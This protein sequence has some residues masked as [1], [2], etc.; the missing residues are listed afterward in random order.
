MESHFDAD[1]GGVRVH[2]DDA[3][4]A[5]AQDVGARAYTLGAHMV[6][7]PGEYAPATAEGR[8]LLAHELTHVIQQYG[9]P[10]GAS[11]RPIRRSAHTIMRA[12][13]AKESVCIRPVRVADDDGKNPTTVPSLD[14]SQRVWGK[15][16]VDLS[17][18]P[19]AIVKKR[20]YKVLD[21]SPNDVPTVE[22][23]ALFTDAGAG[24]GC[25]S[26]FVPE[27]FQQG[28][29]TSKDISGGGGT[30]DAGKNDA[31]V[32]VVEGV[33]PTIV[34]HEIGHALGYLVH[35]PVD[36]IMNVT[37]AR[38]DQ[39]EKE[40]VVKVIC[41]KV[42]TFPGAATAAKVDCDVPDA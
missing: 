25:I 26:L 1:F 37:A 19:A 5:S 15:C 3:A 18:K 38:H 4:G 31:K 13:A 28:G 23:K 8:R 29:L 36:S 17:V 24:G 33:D 14:S 6:F 2:T 35:G 30:Y 34:A 27:T 41:D 22:E 40:K 42:R 32:V 9:A 20:D 39:A 11:D 12:K 7:A 21:E 16:C 10:S